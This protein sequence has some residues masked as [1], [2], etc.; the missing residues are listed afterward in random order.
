[1]Y[2]Y[3]VSLNAGFG[4]ISKDLNVLANNKYEALCAA[5][6]ICEREHYLAFFYDIEA[7]NAMGVSDAERKESFIYIDPT[8]VDPSARPAYMAKTGVTCKK[9]A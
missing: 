3:I 7:M 6:S 1:M 9:V 8:K 5:L 4:V 2:K